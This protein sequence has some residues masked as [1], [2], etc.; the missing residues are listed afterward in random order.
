MVHPAQAGDRLHERQRRSS[1][2][3]RCCKRGH[4][5]GAPI[6]K[7]CKFAVKPVCGRR[8]TANGRAAWHTYTR[9]RA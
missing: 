4:P 2:G 6:L 5:S 8:T 3:A 7:P 1:A 9:S